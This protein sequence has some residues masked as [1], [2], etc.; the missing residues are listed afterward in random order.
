MSN[1]T[2]YAPVPARMSTAKAFA[3]AALTVALAIAIGA[4]MAA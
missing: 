4:M 1:Y 2:Y 3:L